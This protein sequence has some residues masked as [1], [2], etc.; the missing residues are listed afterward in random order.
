MSY[1][2]YTEYLCEKGHYWSANCYFDDG[3][4]CAVCGGA[5]VWRHA[6]D[7]T[8]GVLSKRQDPHG[9]TRPA[10]LK[11]LRYEEYTAKRPIYEIPEKGRI[12]P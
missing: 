5:P 3:E 11:I 9:A 8:N 2:G 7:Q 6:V 12:N 1:E 4:P 10:K